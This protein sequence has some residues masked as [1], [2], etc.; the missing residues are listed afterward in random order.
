M[1]LGLER[2]G[3]TCKWQVEIDPFARKVLA[4]H[5]PNVRQHDDVKTFPPNK[6]EDWSV[7]LIA[8][9]F[10]CQDLSTGGVQRGINASRSG[11]FSEIIRLAR[12]LQPRFLLLENVTAL[13]HRNEWM[14]AVLG[15]ISAIGFDAEWDCL[16]AAAFGA[17]HIRD[18]V[19]ILA[20]PTGNRGGFFEYPPY[21]RNSS[22]WTP[23]DFWGK[24]REKG[25]GTLERRRMDSLRRAAESG[26]LP[27]ADGIPSELAGYRGLGNAVVP[28]VAEWIGRR[29]L[30]AAS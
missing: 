26:V 1:D 14:G 28:Q 29:I 13:I 22:F 20:Y 9:G 21:S 12:D 15:A 5:W 24:E 10:P 8:G 27:V 7:D 3:M 18:R 17:D 19:F 16:P 6:T 4:K 11:L 25:I 30:A 2:A 23:C